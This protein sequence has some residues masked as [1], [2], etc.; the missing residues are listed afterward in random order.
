MY[1][2]IFLLLI[3]VFFLAIGQIFLIGCGESEPTPKM[4]APEVCQYVNQALPN[5]YEYVSS[6]M[7]Y[8][9][10]YTALKAEYGEEIIDK[11]SGTSYVDDLARKFLREK[12]PEG[13]W[14]VYVEVVTEI[15]QLKNGQ[16][17]IYHGAIETNTVEYV[18][19]ENTGALTK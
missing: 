17:S 9:Y 1:K 10:R 19:D 18:F 15:Q 11:I 12:Y 5:E 6:T 7:R 4:T 2:K 13:S 14:R 3:L 16:W 8:E